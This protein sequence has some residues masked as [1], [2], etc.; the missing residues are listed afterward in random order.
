M[1]RI[2]TLLCDRSIFGEIGR[3]A[4]TGK[5][6]GVRMPLY[7]GAPVRMVTGEKRE[8][9]SRQGWFCASS[10]VFEAGRRE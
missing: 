8:K 9:R 6:K 7:S 5:R 4:G 1:S 3:A 10:E 2:V